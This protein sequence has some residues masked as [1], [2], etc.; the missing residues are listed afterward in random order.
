M[1]QVKANQEFQGNVVVDDATPFVVVGIPAFNEEE[2]IAAVVLGAQKHA[3]VVVVVDDGSSDLT[4]DVARA[5]GAYVVRHRKNMG[6][7]AALRS[8]FD[9]AVDV[10]ADIVVTLDGDGQHDPSEIPLL[11]K[12]I[13]NL[14]A[15]MV[16]GSRFSGAKNEMPLYRFFGSIIINLMVNFHANGKAVS[17]TQSGFRAY[18]RKALRDI[19]IIVNGIGVDSEILLK[20][21]ANEVK[22]KEIPVSCRYRGV[23]GSTYNPVLH[24]A[25]VLGIIMAYR[26]DRAFGL[27]LELFKKLRRRI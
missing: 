11:L 12:P 1:V 15:D 26:F 23:D 14:E 20:A 10:G 4:A 8:L 19:D 13:K 17:D 27:G 18:N 16:V 24:T 21:Y 3:N 7:G 2:S 25:K 9:K 22:I 6:K 5:H